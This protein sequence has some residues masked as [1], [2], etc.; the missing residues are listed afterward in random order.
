MKKSWEILFSILIV[1]RRILTISNLPKQ[2]ASI[3]R[4]SVRVPGFN[5]H[6]DIS[7]GDVIMRAASAVGF[8][9]CGRCERRTVHY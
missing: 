4:Y 1:V 3:A 5:I 9:P 6:D 2:S 7:L 8:R